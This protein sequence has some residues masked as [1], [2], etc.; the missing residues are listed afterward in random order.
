MAE[1][2]PSAFQVAASRPE[3]ET[4]E[5]VDRLRDS[6]SILAATLQLEGLWVYREHRYQRCT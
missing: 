2:C 6:T 5:R 1:L 4:D 3:C